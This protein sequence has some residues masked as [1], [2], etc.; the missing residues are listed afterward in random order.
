MRPAVRRRPETETASPT[1][2]RSNLSIVSVSAEDP[3][4][5]SAPGRG[6]N[7]RGEKPGA[8]DGIP[9]L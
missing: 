7:E 2:R 6:E 3:S 5:G 4:A 1:S 9:G 8:R